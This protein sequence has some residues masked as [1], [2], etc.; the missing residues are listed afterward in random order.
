MLLQRQLKALGS[1]GF[2]TTKKNRGNYLRYVEPALATLTAEH[3]SDA[4]WPFL[5]GDLLHGIHQR[6]TSRP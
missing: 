2:L 6:W 4:R 5:S 1:F 3:V